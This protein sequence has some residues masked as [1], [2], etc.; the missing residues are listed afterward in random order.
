MQKE[1]ITVKG[2][3]VNIGIKNPGGKKAIIL[4]HGLG[5]SHMTLE[6]LAGRI[7]LKDHKVIVFDLPGH[8]LSEKLDKEHNIDNY[9]KFL[10]DFITELEIKKCTV[11]GHCLGAQ[12]AINFENR[13]P[14]KVEK[15]ILI[16][17]IPNKV[18]ASGIFASLYYL[19]ALALPKPLKRGWLVNMRKIIKHFAYMHDDIQMKSLIDKM[20]KKEIKRL[21]EDV[22][23]QGFKSILND[24]TKELIA[25][26]RAKTY[27]IISEKDFVFPA[28]EIV[29]MYKKIPQ[30]KFEILPKEGHLLVLD[31]P[32]KVAMK[33]N[34]W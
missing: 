32:E 7:N 21:N 14:E 6:K 11:L 15:L 9:A 18:Y 22:I 5:S 1:K 28:K 23:T 25:K 30:V 10:N 26:T 33:I 13:Y 12:I 17:P 29:R 20:T 3:K 19:I 27:I 31:S 4:V 2:K 24:K 16:T 34:K 8:Y